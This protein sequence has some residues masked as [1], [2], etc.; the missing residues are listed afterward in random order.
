MF[1]ITLNL[2]ALHLENEYMCRNQD[3]TE[4]FQITNCDIIKK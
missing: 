4:L 2:Y 1:K 3:T